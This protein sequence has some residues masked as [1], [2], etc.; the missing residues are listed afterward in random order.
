[1]ANFNTDVNI[2][3]DRGVSLDQSARIFKANYGDGYEQRVGAGINTLPESWSLSW[4]TRSSADGNKIIKFLED[5]NG[6]EAFDWYP[7]DT[8][9]DS[10][11]TSKIVNSLKDTNQT[12][13]KRY[14]GATVTADGG[15]TSTITSINTAGDT[16]SLSSDLFTVTAAGNFLTDVRYKIIAINSTDFTAI[17]AEDSNIGTNFTATGNGAS[18]GTG[19]AVRIGYTIKPTKKYK[20]E[21][22]TA[23]TPFL[24]IKT[25]T[26]TFVKVF[27]P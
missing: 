6:T 9:I 13:T 2:V 23:V 4:N 22:W 20:C 7:P 5:R 26:A 19:T 11:I 1:M 17:G 15:T 12:F 8:L 25:V 16:L 14:L 24:G 27:E 10:E 18:N 21:A 3:P